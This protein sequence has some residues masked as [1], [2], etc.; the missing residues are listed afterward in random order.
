MSY[1]ILFDSALAAMLVWRMLINMNA[2][3]WRRTRIGVV[4]IN[5]VIGVGALCTMLTWLYGFELYEVGHLMIDLAV[6]ARLFYGNRA[7][8]RFLQREPTT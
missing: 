8:D 2:I 6:V 1:V 5:L 3:S 4:A 7:A